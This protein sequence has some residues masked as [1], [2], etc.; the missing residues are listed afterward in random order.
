MENNSMKVSFFEKCAYGCGDMASCLFWQTFSMFLLFFYTDVFGISAGAAGTMFLFV[1]IFDI[2]NDPFIG[3]M[4]DRTKSRFGKFRPWILYGMVPFGILGFLMFYTPELATSAKLVYAYVTYTTMMV[5]YSIVNIPYGA[6]IGVITSD[7]TER[8]SLSA[9][10]TVFAFVGGLIVQAYT[11]KMVDYFGLLKSVDGTTVNE[12]FGYSM[13]MGIYAVLAIILFTVTFLGTKERVKPIKEENN[14]I[15]ID[16]KDL[17]KN[18]PWILLTLVSILTC[19]YVALRNGSILYY[20]KYYVQDTTTEF[21]GFTLDALFMVVGSIFSIVG[22][23]SLKPIS[24]WLGKKNTYIASMALGTICS[25]AY[26]FLTPDQI[27]AMFILQVICNFAVGPAMAM[28]WSMYADTADYSEYKTGRRA[29][30]L[31]YSSA[32]SAQKMGWALGGSLTGY[33]LAYY[34]FEANTVLSPETQNGVLVIF[35]FM[36]VIWSILAIIV[37]FFYKL[38]EKTVHHISQELE[39]MKLEE[40]ENKDFTL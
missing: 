25:V 34:G 9:Y 13:A 37:L 31:I 19:L 28:M 10:R 18:V 6:L 33:L 8:T 29:T 22:T 11:K 23:M 12:Q 2:I 7:T 35:S 5:I 16:L 20:F 24:K 36:P 21:M 3:S 1:R 14:A 4:A 40:V 30:G 27:A 26:Y 39:R 32:S 17:M 38:D 15:S